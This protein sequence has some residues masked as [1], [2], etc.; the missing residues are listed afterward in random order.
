L[1]IFDPHSVIFGRVR[2]RGF[3]RSVEVDPARDAHREDLFTG[4][5]LLRLHDGRRREDS[6]PVG[7]PEEDV[8]NEVSIH[9]AVAKGELA[10]TA[11]S[12]LDDTH[13]GFVRLG[14][15]DVARNGGDLHQFGS[16]FF[17]LRNVKIHLVSVETAERER[18][19]KG[20]E[21]EV[22]TF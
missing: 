5:E 7:N 13:D 16:G 10:N 22:S 4:P 2:T 8:L 17:G 14:R 12:V 1:A 6:V 9:E 11:E 15:D 3:G 21:R 20:N 19:R 18:E